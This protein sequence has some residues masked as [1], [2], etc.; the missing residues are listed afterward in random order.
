MKVSSSSNTRKSSRR[1]PLLVLSF[2]YD[3]FFSLDI[4]SAEDLP[5]YRESSS[6]LCYSSTS[7]GLLLS[8]RYKFTTVKVY[9]KHNIPV[10]PNNSVIISS[11]LYF[12]KHSFFLRCV[13][14]I[15]ALNLRRWKARHVFRYFFFLVP[16]SFM[17]PQTYDWVWVERHRRRWPDLSRC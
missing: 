16:F 10:N 2:I 15:F 1:L 14:Q 8:C 7:G 3:K 13:R 4:L 6:L 9:I 5:I 12:L 11:L 17:M